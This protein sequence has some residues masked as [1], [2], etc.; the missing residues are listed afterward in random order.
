[1]M[2]VYDA[3]FYALSAI[4]LLST[5]LAITRRN[6]VHA[7]VYL[8]LSFFGTAVLFYL[9][10]A[11][12]LAAL[13]VIIYAGAIMVLFLFIIMTM[14]T[15]EPITSTPEE[16]PPDSGLGTK[17]ACASTRHSSLVTRH[18][19]Y[20]RQWVLPCALGVS[21]F[22]AAGFV[23]F[24]APDAR[25]RLVPAMAAPAE[26][27]AFLFQHYWFPVEIVSLLLFVALVGALYLGKRES[28]ASLDHNEDL[29]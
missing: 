16:L 8:V 24:S 9:L 1:M 15:E 4:I 23:I 20:R 18:S 21:C 14:R 22:A 26:F 3:I 29:S 5:L 10:G 2:V 13:E 11:P 27:G 19:S 25:L 7:V 28:N 6:L 12:L 17:S